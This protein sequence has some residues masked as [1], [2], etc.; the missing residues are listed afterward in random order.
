M[1]IC[2]GAQD[3]ILDIEQ[4]IAAKNNQNA[5]IPPWERNKVQ[6]PESENKIYKPVNYA[7]QEEV[8]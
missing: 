2:K 1:R 3:H 8:K 5:P 6:E 7:Q 4:K